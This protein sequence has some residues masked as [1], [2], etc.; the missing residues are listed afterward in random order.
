[1]RQSQNHLGDKDRAFGWLD[2]A[3]QERSYLMAFL[4]V[5]PLAD[6]LRSD[7]RFDDF[8]A[9]HWIIPVINAADSLIAFFASR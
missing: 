8:T 6:P 5:I 2:K 7:P 3:Y 1:M 4:R 9:A